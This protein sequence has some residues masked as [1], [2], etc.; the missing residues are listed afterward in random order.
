MKSIQLKILL[1][2]FS[3]IFFIIHIQAQKIY[4]KP[5]IG[6]STGVEKDYLNLQNYLTK[7]FED[8]IINSFSLMQERF[9]YGKGINFEMMMGSNIG[10]KLNLELSFFYHKSGEN[11][12]K[13]A[14]AY[15]IIDAYNVDY[16][17]KY[18]LRGKSFGLKPNI[19]YYFKRKNFNPYL[20]AGA[21]IAINSLN[22]KV[23]LTIYNTIPSYMPIENIYYKYEYD[24]KLSLGFHF[25]GGFELKLLEDFMFFTE[26]QYSHLNYLAE[27]AEITEYTIQDKDA[28]NELSTN[29]RYVEYVESFNSSDNENENTPYKKPKRTDS[30]SQ[31]G[32]ITGVKIN[33]F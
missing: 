9:S 8:T 10:K 22:E 27:K 26:I 7:V 3:S 20:K 4:I 6:Y 32:L 19:I 5:G 12:L 1:V 31:L 33:L 2:A 28:L 14:D 21:I 18:V 29:E 30:F 15:R 25:G 24:K 16:N 11:E 23:N 13:Q 17:Y